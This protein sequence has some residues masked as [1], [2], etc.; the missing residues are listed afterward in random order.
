MKWILATAC[1]L[2]VGAIGLLSGRNTPTTFNEADAGCTV[3]DA[4]S[5]S[6]GEGA[7]LCF[8]ALGAGP[9]DYFQTARETC[10]GQRVDDLARQLETKPK[11][12]AVARAYSQWMRGQAPGRTPDKLD[13][14]AVY[15][16]CLKGLGED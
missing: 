1:V 4:P 7:S 6:R 9:S 10:A 8:P 5:G 2:V 3:A 16:G 13:L 12:G 14:A 11:A 15:R